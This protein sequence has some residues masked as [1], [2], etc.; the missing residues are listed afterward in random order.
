MDSAEFVEWM[1]YFRIEPF[2]DIIA[3]L[4]HGAATA[5]LANIN[6]DVEKRP[7]PYTA[8]DFIYWRA[9]KEVAPDPTPVLLADAERQS[10]LIQA[11]IFGIAPPEQD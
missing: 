11:A 3:D 5:T 4:R 6:R 7:E 2:G 9:T 1:A 10:A 8:D